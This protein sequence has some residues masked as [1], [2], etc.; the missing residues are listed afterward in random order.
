[1]PTAGRSHI[2]VRALVALIGVSGALGAVAYG[3]MRHDHLAPHAV[4][5]SYVPSRPG[6]PRIVEH[7]EKLAIAT[8]AGFAFAAGRHGLRFECRLD[9][10]SWRSCRARVE[11]T[12]LAPGSHALSVRVVD[13]RGRRSRPARF[14]WRI[15]QPKKF[16]IVPRLSGLAA[17]YPGAPPQPLSLTI[18]N[19]NPVPIFVTGL[20]VWVGASVPGCAGAENLL[21]G[22]SGATPTAPLEVPPGGTAS[23]PATGVSAP[24][25]QLR[26]LPTDQDDCQGAR[27]PLQFSGS[28][29]G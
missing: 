6:R 14:R 20:R 21:L 26:D 18:E 1:M 16:S 29:W 3:A 13:R 28:A 4:A 17:L 11:F 10:A 27:F 15:L 24:T 8:V 5:R 25:I 2:A 9:A 7:P 23:L 19:P 12:G 22:E